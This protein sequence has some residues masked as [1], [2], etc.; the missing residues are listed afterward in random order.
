LNNFLAGQLSI[1]NVAVDPQGK[2]PCSTTPDGTPVQ[3]P[4]CLLGLPLQSPNQSRATLNRDAALYAQDTWR[5][6]KRLTL[7][8]GLRWEY[9]GVQRSGDSIPESNYYLGT[10]PNL[11]Q[12]IRH[13][14][15][16]TVGNS[17]I[18]GLWRPDYN[19]FGPRIGFAWD[20]FGDGSTSLRGGYGISYERNFGEVFQNL[21]FNPPNFA[22]AEADAGTPQFPTLS[23]SNSNLGPF[24]GSSGTIMFPPSLARRVDADIT[25][26]YA[27]TWS[28]SLQRQLLPNTVLDLSY[29]GSHGIHLYSDYLSDLPGSGVV[30]G[31]DDPAINPF[32]TLSRQYEN[33]TTR[34]N[35]GSSI[36]H[37]LQVR[38]QGQNIWH[39]GLSFNTNYTWAHAIDNAST[40]LPEYPNEVSF[41]LGSLDPFNPALDRGDSAFDL[42]QRF[43][44]SAI[45]E[46]PWLRTSGRNW[47]RQILS[48]WSVAPVLSAS[49][50]N[51]FSVSDC[52]Q[53]FSICPRYIPSAPVSHTGHA[54]PTGDPDFFRYISLPAP[55]PYANPE[56]GISDFPD[57]TNVAAPPC[58]FPL[59]MTRRDAFRGPG[60]W[61]LDLGIYKQFRLREGW[62]L[63]FRGELFNA[64]NHPN[65]QVNTDQTDASGLD[66]VSA[67]KSGN[68]N[69]QLALK[70]TF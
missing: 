33:M 9:Y 48:G 66:F 55:V 5:A 62:E 22:L 64:F 63:Q 39:S 34:G 13:G 43:V 11:A 14:Q 54:V 31:G 58:A 6:R 53:A 20:L 46:S 1:F 35:G 28:A 4:D 19:N 40:A 2:F 27:E 18:H 57:C 3:T 60:Q 17:P 69:V 16:L 24:A 30:Y 15:V 37:A 44:A 7:S 47:K 67:S 70:L 29:S 25:T 49:T 45:W 52:T 56:I 8:L 36:Y 51:P 21:T 50:G 38:V 23:I 61:N 10:G 59:N 32:S 42:R 12:Q 65:F 41:R 68:R 26:A